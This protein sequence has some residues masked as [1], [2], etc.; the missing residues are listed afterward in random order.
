[1][2]RMPKRGPMPKG[3]RLAPE[4][5]S[6]PDRRP[7]LRA[8]DDSDAVSAGP[9]PCPV[10]CDKWKDVWADVSVGLTPK[11]V[12]LLETAFLAR[13][14]LEIAS[15]SVREEGAVCYNVRGE[16]I[17]NPAT[18]VADAASATL[19]RAADQLGLSPKSRARIMG[20]STDD[21]VETAEEIMFGV[22][23]E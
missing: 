22:S 2:T 21:D 15:A 14:R 5:L 11:D 12:P 9:L 18:K 1:M 6:E 16:P 8:D 3:L 23:D 7:A 13:E 17:V 19:L 20:S 4:E 10:T